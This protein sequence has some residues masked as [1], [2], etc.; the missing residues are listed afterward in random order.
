M[1]PYDL[2]PSLH[3][4]E[5]EPEVLDD[6]FSPPQHDEPAKAAQPDATPAKMAVDAA[7]QSKSPF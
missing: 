5:P 2:D 6:G 7:L 3:T 4:A 1:I